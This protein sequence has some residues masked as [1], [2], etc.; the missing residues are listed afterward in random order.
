ME[1]K[2]IEGPPTRGEMLRR[3]ERWTDEEDRLVAAPFSTL[4]LNSPFV[5]PIA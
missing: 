4:P 3:F 1:E 2:A 5:P